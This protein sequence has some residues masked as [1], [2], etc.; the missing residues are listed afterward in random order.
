MLCG[1]APVEPLLY[2]MTASNY[3]TM[4]VIVDTSWNTVYE[5]RLQVIGRTFICAIGNNIL[6]YFLEARGY[7]AD[8][9]AVPGRS[10]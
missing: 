10:K 3:E 7:V 4:Q 8:E 6:D 9:I 2:Y 5:N 1:T